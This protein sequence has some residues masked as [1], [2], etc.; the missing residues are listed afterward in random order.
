RSG[1]RIQCL[2]ASPMSLRRILPL[3]VLIPTA[4]L[5]AQLP[6]ATS[7]MLRRLFA[8][9]DFAPQGFGPARW[10]EGGA[11]YTTVEPSREVNG[12]LDIV[13]YAT[14]TGDRTVY[15]SAR[16]MVPPGASQPLD[17]DDY[18]WSPDG[19]KLLLFTNTQRVWRENTRGDYWVLD[20]TSGKL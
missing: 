4:Q 2:E 18:D 6:A 17:F 20:R 12:G 13:R 5:A 15:V 14:R 7:D 19:T 10:I 11:A 9:R 3:I 1:H 8:S 16:Q